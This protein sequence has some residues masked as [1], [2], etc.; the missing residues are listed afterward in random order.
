MT[1]TWM[2][3]V[4]TR[5]VLTNAHAKWDTSVMDA[6]VQVVLKMIL[7]I[8][9]YVTNF[10]WSSHNFKQRY[11]Y[12]YYCRVIMIHIFYICRTIQLRWKT[13]RQFIELSKRREVTWPQTTMYYFDYQ[14]NTIGLYWEWKVT[15]WKND[16]I[17]FTIRQKKSS[18]WKNALNHYRNRQRA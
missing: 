2:Q 8:F 13:I 6:H 7:L 15:F 18:R 12:M 4:L 1:A 17:G 10:C 14:R 5:M 16:I 3:T 9:P 11:P